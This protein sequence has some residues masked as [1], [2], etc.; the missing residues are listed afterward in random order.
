M[1]RINKRIPKEIANGL[2]STQYKFYYDEEGK[3]GDAATCYLL[4]Q[5]EDGPYKNQKHILSIQWRYGANEVR[6]YPDD[7]PNI[8]FITPVM[9]SNI[10]VQG[11]I[12]LDILKKGD[13]QHGCTYSP[14]YG[15]DAFYESI[16][17]LLNVPTPNS[18]LN[19]EA[20]KLYN[21]KGN[22]DDYSTYLDDYYHARISQFSKFF[23]V[24]E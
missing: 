9:H 16:R 19:G 6:E 10:G 17:L 18:P 21:Q 1:K 15:I 20:A 5:P 4:F 8:R 13:P 23:S 24:F 3:L 7:P 12:C 22:S 14:S 2:K 11:S